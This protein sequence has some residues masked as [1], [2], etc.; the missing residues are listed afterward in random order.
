MSNT[1]VEKPIK[2]KTKKSNCNFEEKKFEI[3][4]RLQK[5]IEKLKE[6]R[7]EIHTTVQLAM[8]MKENGD[9]IADHVMIGVVE[10]FTSYNNFS[11][12]KNDIQENN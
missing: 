3:L 12:L 11:V 10:A 7:Q 6:A 5:A 9:D 2:I 8:K 1:L 4:V